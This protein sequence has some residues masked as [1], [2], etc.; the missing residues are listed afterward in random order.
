[1]QIRVSLGLKQLQ[2]QGLKE[3]SCWLIQ[4]NR[5]VLPVKT[6]DS[7][8]CT[9]LSIWTSSATVT[10]SSALDRHQLRC[11]HT[12][13]DE[14]YWQHV[15]CVFVGLSKQAKGERRYWAMTPRF[16]EV[17]EQGGSIL[18]AH[19][20]SLFPIKKVYILCCPIVSIVFGSQRVQ[21]SWSM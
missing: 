20:Q 10:S 1:M 9:S 17:R 15:A 18:L 2:P 16:V 11:I 12:G 21:E 7:I 19:E 3:M 14:Q 6:G 8:I 13:C 5:T 4:E